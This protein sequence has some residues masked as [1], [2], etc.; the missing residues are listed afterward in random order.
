MSGE[1]PFLDTNVLLYAFNRADWRHPRAEELIVPRAVVSVQVLNE[2]VAV[3]RGKF[4]LPWSE[5]LESLAIIKGALSDP[6]SLTME[7]HQAA[8][9]I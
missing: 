2:F 9:D 1:Q 4:R 7:I 6:R 3:A 8:S 5:I